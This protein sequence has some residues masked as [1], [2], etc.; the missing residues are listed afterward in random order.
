MR[1][2]THR[3]VI[4]NKPVITITSTVYDR[5]ALDTN[6]NIPLINSL[7][8][9][10]YLTSNSSKVRETVSNDGALE[11]LVCMLHGCF[12][13][14]NDL[15]EYDLGKISKHERARNIHK[16]KTLAMCSWK[17][18]LAFQCLVLT[19]TRGTEQIRKQVVSSGVLPLLATVLDNY[20][21]YHKNFDFVKGCPIHMSFRSLASREVYMFLRNGTDESYEQYMSYLI[22]TEF[23]SEEELV[24]YFKDQELLLST[25][26]VPSD[27]S[28]IWDTNTDDSKQATSEIPLMNSGFFRLDSEQ[29][30][31]ISI[32]REFYMG[33]IIPK[34]DD[35][36]WSLQL[37]AFI[38]KYTYMKDQLQ[39]VNIV[40]SLS[41][42]SIVDKVQKRLDLLGFI[43]KGLDIIPPSPMDINMEH[44]HNV[45]DF[46]G[47]DIDDPFL[48]ELE[49]I[50]Q[51]C[52]A[53][54]NASDKQLQL[55]N[56]YKFYNIDEVIPGSD[57]S[58][59]IV[60]ENSLKERFNKKWKYEKISKELDETTWNAMNSVVTLNLFPLVERYT[61][62][63][64]NPNDMIYWS[65]VIM[66]NSCRKN[67][68]TCV[69]QCANFA[70]GKWESYP[71]Q[72][73]KC[74]RCK[75]TKYCSRECQL[76][77]WI[78]HRYWCHEVSSNTNSNGTENTGTNTPNDSNT[79]VLSAANGPNGNNQ[80]SNEDGNTSALDTEQ[81]TTG[82]TNNIIRSEHI[83]IEDDNGNGN[84]NDNNTSGNLLNDGALD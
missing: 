48:L 46:K 34:Q 6:S 42:R 59:R 9:L 10:T 70:C 38:S 75:R 83:E 76:T 57:V 12:L 47:M 19:G 45:L 39:N 2:T 22:G 44:L 67:E 73:A 27:F 55:Q 4:L 33:K 18:T 40:D 84:N 68:I 61:V 11:R 66:R 60:L 50:Q 72:F 62:T 51:N 65:S 69:R 56:P 35:V 53:L 26:T 24:E 71:R 74:R 77:G 14:L 81:I 82:N 78:Y 36:I 32:P 29:I 21:I 79:D 63:N 15:L 16:E 41:F 1:E 28:D 31:V 43:P 80:N 49:H 23:D 37:L 13:N 58:E 54:E 30:P 20:F 52:I 8:H 7:N 17:W 5:R 25:M 3:S 64:E